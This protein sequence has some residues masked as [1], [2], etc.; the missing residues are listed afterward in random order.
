[1]KFFNGEAAFNKVLGKFVLSQ[2][3]KVFT[4]C[5]LLEY[6]NLVGAKFHSNCVFNLL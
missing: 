4:V 6:G 2:F 5:E 3:D 1:M